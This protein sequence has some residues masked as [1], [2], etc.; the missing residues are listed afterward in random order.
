MAQMGEERHVAA[1]A[2][3][4]ITPIHHVQC[5]P[6]TA[7][8]NKKKENSAGSQPVGE[9]V[10]VAVKVKIAKEQMLSCVKFIIE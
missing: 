7:H 1:L 6:R 4:L 5:R 2:D 3:C 8:K 9:R 10:K